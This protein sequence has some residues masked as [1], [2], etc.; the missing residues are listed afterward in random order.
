MSK[1]DD[2]KIKI[3]LDGISK[4]DD[5]FY[6][7]TVSGYTT[8]PSLMRSAGIKDYEDYINQVLART[9]K[10][11]S[12]EVFADEPEELI[13]QARKISSF[14]DN[15]YVKIPITYCNGDSTFREIE[16]LSKGGVKLNITAIMHPEQ[17]MVVEPVIDKETPTII[18][19]FAG[20]VADT[21]RDPVF[22]ADELSWVF[23]N[24]PN[25]QLLWASCREVLNIWQAESCNFD[26]ITCS[27]S[28]IKKLDGIERDLIEYSRETVQQFHRDAVF[29]GYTI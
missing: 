22:L 7:P 14:G 23:E 27:A 21:G 28:I 24:K 9:E 12:F 29:A 18:S 10:P 4:F 1:I 11:V 25:T 5:T 16:E 2:L 6:N 19:F 17:C 3:F 13:R 8:N 20:R 15:I 26:I